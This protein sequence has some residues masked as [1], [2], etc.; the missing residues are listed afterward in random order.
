MAESCK[1][2][3]TFKNYSPLLIWS[4]VWSSRRAWWQLV[5][6]NLLKE[7][8]YILMIKNQF[9]MT[10]GKIENRDTVQLT[11]SSRQ[12]TKRFNSMKL[13]EGLKLL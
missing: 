11:L 2:K 9:L 5:T 13:R 12:L 10:S 4:L 6:V 3:P 7:L 1:F 8:V